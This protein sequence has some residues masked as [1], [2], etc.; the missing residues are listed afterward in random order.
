MRRVGVRRL[1]MRQGLA[2][3]LGVALWAGGMAPAWGQEAEN[4]AARQALMDG[5]PDSAIATLRPLYDAGTHDNQTLFL[6]ATA[7]RSLD[8]L[9][10]SER[11]LR[12]LLARA[13][14][15]GRVKLDL[16]E[17]LYRQRRFEEAKAL[18]DEVQAANP[19]AEVAT[20]VG[21]FDREVTAAT[22]GVWSGHAGA[23]LLFDSN[24]NQ[25]TSQNVVQIFGLPFQL[26]D[27]A[28]GREDTAARL[29]GGVSYRRALETVDVEVGAAAE[30][31][32]Y[33]KVNDAD[34][35]WLSTR[36]A[37]RWGGAD[38]SVSLPYTLSVQR[39][40]N[41]RAWTVFDHGPAPLLA[42][43]LTD[44]TSLYGSVGVRWAHYE[45]DVARDSVSYSASL[46]VS[47]L[48]SDR[49][50]LNAD[51]WIARKVAGR[52]T[53]SN[54]AKGA[55]VGATLALAE[56]WTLATTGAVRQ[57]NY[58]GREALWNAGR[59]D[60]QTV[61]SAAL[62]YTIRSLD[63]DVILSGSYVDTDSSIDIYGYRQTT[64]ATSFMK[65]F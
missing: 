17:N 9:E 38:W 65:R 55:S 34:S 44:T 58:R 56:D 14:E 36:A 63:A 51:T 6:L 50:T 11:L 21:A 26:S 1:G 61:A 37:V 30:H 59:D 20:A 18:L 15:A 54:L 49:L 52:E 12:D 29:E 46:G 40:G 41:D 42:Y 57:S 16:A 3:G 19:P 25:A 32:D 35:L 22:R 28:R 2:A 62:T 10:D 7:Y 23:G 27:D 53:D 64:V 45:R 24:A 8:R 43:R 33:F 4:A 39:V 5:D 48:A 13:P 60:T 47:T 31:V